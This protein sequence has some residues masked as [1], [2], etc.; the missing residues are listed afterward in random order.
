[1]KKSEMTKKQS[2]IGFRVS[3]IELVKTSLNDV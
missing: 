3:V 1:M 2:Y